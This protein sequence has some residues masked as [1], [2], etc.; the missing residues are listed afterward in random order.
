MIIR[1]ILAVLIVFIFC[2]NTNAQTVLKG[3]IY[4]TENDSVIASAT[5]F[6]LT[7]KQS[8]HSTIDGR[9]MIIAAE[10]D[11]VV[12]STTGFKADTIT[13]IY[14]MLVTQLE[15]TLDKQIISL[16]PVNLVSS[17]QADSLARRDYYSHVFEKQPGITG[18]NRPAYGVGVVFSPLSYF[19]REA[20]QK[21]QLKMRL[22]R[23]EREYYIDRCFPL[24]WVRQVTGL[25]G[26][27]LSLFMFW[28]R[29]GYTFCRK[30]DREKMLI[31]INDKLK[32]FKKG[33]SQHEIHH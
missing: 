30:T 9:Y 12:F 19:S 15:I 13:I 3:K 7:N 21:R 10:G 14:W 4:D 26:D 5:V 28:Y 16:Q 23:E 22:I 1:P 8:T 27:S 29:P 6:N 33:S 24:E 2:F 11:R 20:R 31:Y 25:Q 32:E 18:R 17:Y